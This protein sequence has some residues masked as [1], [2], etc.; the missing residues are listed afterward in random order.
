MIRNLEALLALHS[1]GT[2]SAAAARLRLTQSAVS[3]RIGALE[4]TL[5]Y[6]VVEPDGRRLR[7]TPR[8]ARLVERAAPLV[9]ELLSLGTALPGSGAAVLTLALADSIASSWGPEVVRAALAGTTALQVQLHAHRSVLVVESVRL[10]RYQLGL[11]AEMPGAAR[12][13]I[14]LPVVE[15]AMVLVHAGL[16]R[17]PSPSL[18]LITIEPGSATWRAV[19]P[20][21]RRESPALLR[22]Q[23]VSVESFAAV[24]QMARAGFGDGLV[25]M[26]VARAAG[27]DQARCRTLPGVRRRVTLHARKTV[28]L[29][30]AVEDLHARL[31]AAA[32]AY[33]EEW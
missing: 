10:G 26:G 23:R 2:V 25:P 11:C 3:K 5:G 13:L 16:G 28:G 4:H 21:L 22:R 1:A 20:L 27:V 12:Y 33:L 18:P 8:G 31:S 19:E 7:L 29:L 17:R 24:L 15:E 6:R 14:R 9:A 30:P 32:R